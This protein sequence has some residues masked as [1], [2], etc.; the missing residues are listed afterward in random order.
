VEL[1]RLERVLAGFEKA[2][3]F[4]LFTD[5][6]HRET[7]QI[8]EKLAE[9]V[10]NLEYALHTMQEELDVLQQAEQRRGATASRV[11]IDDEDRESISSYITADGRVPAACPCKGLECARYDLQVVMSPNPADAFSDHML[12]Y[13]KVSPCPVVCVRGR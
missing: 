1:R 12:K 13:H 6:K 7:L 9:Q 5:E 10:E 4:E 3:K 11:L 8:N 2:R